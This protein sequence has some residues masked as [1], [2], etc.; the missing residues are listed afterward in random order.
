MLPTGLP[1]KPTVQNPTS[2]SRKRSIGINIANEKK[3]VQTI[4]KPLTK[5]FRILYGTEEDLNEDTLTKKR[6]RSRDDIPNRSS[7]GIQITNPPPRSSFSLPRQTST[8]SI[9][10]P[11]A[12]TLAERNVASCK[13][14]QSLALNIVLVHSL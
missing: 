10:K 1:I 12:E 3:K 9:Q 13:N 8:S 7:F 14:N 11:S 6:N 2:Q 5:L 4:T